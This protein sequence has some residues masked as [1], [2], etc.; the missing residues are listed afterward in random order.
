MAFLS[1]IDLAA[2]HGINGLGGNHTLDVMVTGLST[3]SLLRALILAGPYVYFWFRRSTDSDRSDRLMAGLLGGVL[4]VVVARICADLLPFEV[5]PEFDPT[6][7]YHRLSVQWGQDM[8]SWSAF[9]SDTAALCL[10]LT[11][12]L[13]TISR[14]ASLVLSLLSLLAF[15]LPRVYAGIHYPHDILAGAVIA[16]AAATVMNLPMVTQRLRPLLVLEAR[17][18]PYFYALAFLAISEETQMF[19][20]LRFLMHAVHDSLRL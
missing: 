13:F 8:E 11:F 2:F 6:S 12:G 16:L 15:V 9:P 5:R 1:R 14:R 4:A 10:A 7:G 3:N 17:M 19:D 18:P 20:G